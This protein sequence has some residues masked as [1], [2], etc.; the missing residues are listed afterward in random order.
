MFVIAGVLGGAILGARLAF[1]H[2]GRKLDA[3]QYAVG[4][5]IL[6]GLIGLFITIAADRMF[7]G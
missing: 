2:G 6:F 4:L 3:L 7:L 5:A 1:R